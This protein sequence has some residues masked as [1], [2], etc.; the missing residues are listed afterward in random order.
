M[1]CKR[2]GKS[3][4]EVK[5]PYMYNSIIEEDTYKCSFRSVDNCGVII[6][7]GHNSRDK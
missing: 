1:H 5:C 6:D 2:H 7:K 3:I 4:L